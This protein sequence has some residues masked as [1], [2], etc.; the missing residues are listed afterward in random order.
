MGRTPIDCRA[1]GCPVRDVLDL[2]GDKWTSLVLSFLSDGSLRFGEL[3]RLVL[4][5]SQRML[6][7]TVR[8]LE[9]HGLISRTVHPTIP[10]NVEYALTPLGE[11]LVPLVRGIVHWSQAHGSEI[12]AARATYDAAIS[13]SR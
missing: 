7:A 1:A 11:S 3:R 6:T 5:I 8:D 13:G 9:R 10:P 2:V 4:G 12:A